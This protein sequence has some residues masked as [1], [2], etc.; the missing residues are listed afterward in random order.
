MYIYFY[1]K[2]T[3]FKNKENVKRLA[4]QKL[5]LKDS[6]SVLKT[7]AI[8]ARAVSRAFIETTLVVHVTNASLNLAAESYFFF[9]TE[10]MIF[11]I[12]LKK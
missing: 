7:K 6:M 10:S 5:L 1:N 12:I 3:H 9:L 11:K 2:R 8:F 4:L